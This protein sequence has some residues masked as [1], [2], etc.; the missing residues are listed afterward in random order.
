VIDVERRRPTRRSSNPAKSSPQSPARVKTKTPTV[1]VGAYLS[2][3]PMG[4]FNMSRFHVSTF[5]RFH[6]SCCVLTCL[7]APIFLGG[8]CR[9]VPDEP[10]SNISSIVVI[11]SDVSIEL[12]KIEQTDVFGSFTL[13]NNGNGDV[14]VVAMENS[15]TCSTIS[16]EAPF[17]VVAGTEV[18][19]DFAIE[20]PS[21]IRKRSVK[22]SV[23]LDSGDVLNIFPSVERTNYFKVSPPRHDFGTVIAGDTPS[24]G[25]EIEVPL[26]TL[27]R[28]KFHPSKG[29]LVGTITGNTLEIQVNSH[30]LQPGR[31]DEVIWLETPT[32][33]RQNV[34]IFG[35]IRSLY[36][37]AVQGN[38]LLVVR[39]DG[40]AV[41]EI[42]SATI[43]GELFQIENAVR[44]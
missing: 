41:P 7:V 3:E 13:R 43:G 19:I 24:V 26:E 25:L 4:K 12:D 1:V 16:P 27:H 42:E 31:F 34:R 33:Y 6:V 11:P 9:R 22:I 40:A 8:G 15:C 44:A 10:N 18:N 29:V 21:E 20:I 17:N 2:V 35:T 30:V 32:G 36:E 14:R 5:P 38:S 23:R 28:L 39:T 37:V